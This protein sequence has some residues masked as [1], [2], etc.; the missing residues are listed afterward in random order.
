MGSEARKPTPLFVRAARA[1]HAR[2]LALGP[3]MG[4]RGR[5]V[6]VSALARAGH[7]VALATVHA[8]SRPD[9]GAAYLWAM[10]FLAGRED[11]PPPWHVVEASR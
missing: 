6:L 5:L 9:Q 4:A 8:W 10:A 7:T 3:N 1:E 2:A 11:L